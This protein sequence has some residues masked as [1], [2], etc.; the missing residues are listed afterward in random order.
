MIY[1]II[2]I[3]IILELYNTYIVNKPLAQDR[4]M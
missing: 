3:Y 2:Y 4:N 1:I